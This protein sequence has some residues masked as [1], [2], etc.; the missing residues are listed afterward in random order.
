MTNLEELIEHEKLAVDNLERVRAMKN[1]VLSATTVTCGNN[2][3]FSQL[4]GCGSTFSIKNVVYVQTLRYVPPSGC[5]DGDYWTNDE[6]RWKCPA[7][8]KHNRLFNKP[9][10]TK[11]KHL[12]NSVVEKYLN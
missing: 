3:E 6:G 1:V 9:E 4:K 12:F 10:I 8:S 5:T 7:C 2:F 11:L